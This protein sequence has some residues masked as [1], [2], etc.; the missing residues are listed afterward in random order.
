MFMCFSYFS[1]NQGIKKVKLHYSYYKETQETLKFNYLL[2]KMLF[3]CYHVVTLLFSSLVLS[4]CVSVFLPSVALDPRRG[5]PTGRAVC[6]PVCVIHM[7]GGVSL[8]LFLSL[9]LSLFQSLSL[10][11]FFVYLY[12]SFCLSF[13]QCFFFLSTASRCSKRSALGFMLGGMQQLLHL[14]GIAIAFLALR[15]YPSFWCRFAWPS[16]VILAH[17][18][19]TEEGTRLL[20]PAAILNVGAEA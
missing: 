10:S 14:L 13:E 16:F 20:Y 19:F 9:C 17:I 18:G 1:N 6:G 11:F 15:C 2:S 12:L 5:R 4:G 3:L 8:S 7:H